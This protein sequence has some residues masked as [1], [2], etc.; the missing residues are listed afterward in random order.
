MV[1]KKD[2]Q[3]YIGDLNVYVINFCFLLANRITS[4]IKFMSCNIHHLVAAIMTGLSIIPITNSP[5]AREFELQLVEQYILTFRWKKSK[6]NVEDFYFLFTSIE[7]YKLA[8]KGI[9]QENLPDAYD[10]ESLKQ[11]APQKKNL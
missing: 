9:V 2:V 3:Y 8:L 1:S 10:N 5:D 11:I 4:N 7:D 6:W